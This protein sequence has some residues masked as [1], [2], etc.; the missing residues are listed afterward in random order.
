M[1]P[2]PSLCISISLESVHRTIVP[3]SSPPAQSGETTMA[4]K[5]YE[6]SAIKAGL[7]KVKIFTEYEGEKGRL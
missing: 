5:G 1:E 7:R 6:L 3:V 2:S 4:E